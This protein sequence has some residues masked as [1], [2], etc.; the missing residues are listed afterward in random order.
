M[1]VGMKAFETKEMVLTEAEFL[2]GIS[3]NLQRP[4]SGHF[5]HMFVDRVLSEMVDEGQVTKSR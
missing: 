3:F 5:Q 4:I 1:I 2:D